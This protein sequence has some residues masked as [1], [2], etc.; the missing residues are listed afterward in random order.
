MSDKAAYSK[1]WTVLE[2]VSAVSA[3]G[4]FLYDMLIGEQFTRTRP[5]EADPSAG[6]IHPWNNHGYVVY[7]TR[8]EQHRFYILACVAIL[9]FLIGVF[10]GVFIKKS[11]RRSKPWETGS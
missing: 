7:L 10:I 4:V 6:R 1:I 3:L 9:L 8:D 5:T 2:V 11:W